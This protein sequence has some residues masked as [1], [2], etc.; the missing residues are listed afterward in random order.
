MSQGTFAANPA[1]S[2]R[3]RFRLRLIVLLVVI[4][5][6]S[7][8]LGW[9]ASIVH[10]RHT[11]RA[12]FENEGWDVR[13]D[14]SHAG[15]TWIRRLLGDQPVQAIY[16]PPIG[17]PPAHDLS[18]ARACLSEATLYTTGDCLAPIPAN[19]EEAY[20]RAAP[21]VRAR[22]I[23]EMY[24]GHVPQRPGVLLSGPGEWNSGTL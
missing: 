23:V 1:Q 7:I 15:T 17:L 18:H 8:W 5:A 11:A 9:N 13:P 6:L 20:L 24:D 19:Q 3:R 16:R 21:E 4:A 2:P 10:Q 12:D 22:I 14:S